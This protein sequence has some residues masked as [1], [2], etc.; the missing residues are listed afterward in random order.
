MKITAIN[1]ILAPKP[2]GGYSQAILVEDSRKI[3]FISGQIPESREGDIPEGFE[4]QCRLVWSNIISQLEA[5]DLSIKNLIKI[6]I[7][8]SSRSYADANSK[9]RNEMLEDHN[10]AL[11]VIITGIY[12]EQWLLEIEAVAM[13]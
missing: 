11:T 13:A 4:S 8:L 12:D 5:G 7:Y 6:T 9:I 10:P 2:A 3:L 1:S